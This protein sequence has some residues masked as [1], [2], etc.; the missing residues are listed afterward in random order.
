MKMT[1]IKLF[2]KLIVVGGLLSFLTL[3]LSGCDC[4]TVGATGAAL[5]G[6]TGAFVGGVSGATVE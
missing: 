3:S 4:R 5:G 6:T 1:F 2:I